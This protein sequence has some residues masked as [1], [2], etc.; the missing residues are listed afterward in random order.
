MKTLGDQFLARSAL[1]DHEHGTVER[2]GAARA[3]HGV[4]ER[5]AL[6]DEL[7]RPLHS[8]DCWWQFPPFGKD[9]RPVF[10][11]KI[12]TFRETPRFRSIWHGS[13]MVSGRF[14]RLFWNSE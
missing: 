11:V 14:R 4:K 12:S 7:I 5:K 13:C 1:T 3:L 2:R 8:P 10:S 9:F 6:P